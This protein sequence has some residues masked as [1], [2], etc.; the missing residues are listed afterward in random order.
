[1]TANDL[2]KVGID[3]YEVAPVYIMAELRCNE[4]GR[5]GNVGPPVLRQTYRKAMIEKGSA[6]M[7][8]GAVAKAIMAGI[9]TI[10][11]CG[12]GGAALTDNER[13]YAEVCLATHRA[14]GGGDSKQGL[15]ECSA[16]IMV[17]RLSPAEFNSLVNMGPEMSGRVL[18]PQ[19]TAPLG[20]TPADYGNL[21]RKT[22]EALPE[23]TRTCGS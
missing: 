20:F 5:G 6:G 16:R 13:R 12:C 10:L 23:I 18:T 19:N 17:P 4:A 11:L 9:A 7:G 22:Q 21:M 15:C 2:R 1:L 8:S 14:F 3:I